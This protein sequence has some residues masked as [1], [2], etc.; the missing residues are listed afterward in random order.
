VQARTIQAAAI[1]YRFR[2]DGRFEALLVTSSS[3]RWTAPKGWIDPGRTG[4]ETAALEA[5]EEAG[6][7][8][9]V[10]EPSLGVCTDTTAD[11]DA[12]EMQVFALLVD[13]VLDHWQEED[14]RRRQWMTVDETSLALGSRGLGRFIEKLAAR[15][16]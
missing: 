5:L 8:G 11:G 1:P 13:R 15:R 12:R 10:E 9:T 6:V 4:A 7:I 14:T 3:G 16:P 2:P